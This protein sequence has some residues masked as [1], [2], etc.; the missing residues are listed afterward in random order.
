MENNTNTNLENG[1]TQPTETVSNPVATETA[2]PTNEEVKVDANTVSS[3]GDQKQVKKPKKNFVGLLVMLVGVVCIISG[4]VIGENTTNKD[5]KTSGTKDDK[6]A[7]KLDVPSN[8]NTVKGY[9]EY[10]NYRY[11]MN[12]YMNVSDT[13][14]VKTT[15]VTRDNTSNIEYVVTSLNNGSKI[16]G[17]NDYNSN[18]EYTSTDSVAWVNAPLASSTK[19]LIDLE[20]IVKMIVDGDPRVSSEE[21]NRYK[22]IFDYNDGNAD[23][24]DVIFDVM[25]QDGYVR[26]ISFDL[27]SF[28]RTEGIST[29]IITIT[30]SSINN[31]GEVQLP[32]TVVSGNSTQQPSQ[33][34]T[35]SQDTTT[36]PNQN[37]TPSVDNSQNSNNPQ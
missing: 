10:Q 14:N 29:Y 25:L 7:D 2:I 36:G 13:D 35:P 1:V 8:T 9:E 34:Q 27:T 18:L 24:K 19:G 32:N 3:S 21:N 4:F 28:V 37:Q 15:E 30:V 26:S 6:P 20:K 11:T 23:Y 16:F 31:A 33:N 17:Y 12:S 22:V 5:D